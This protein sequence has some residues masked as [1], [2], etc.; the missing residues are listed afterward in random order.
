MDAWKCLVIIFGSIQAVRVNLKKIYKNTEAFEFV[1]AP[2]AL[3][4]AFAELYS[5]HFWWN[6]PFFKWPHCRI[7]IRCRSQSGAVWTGFS[8][9]T[10]NKS[11]NMQC[12]YSVLFPFCHIHSNSSCGTQAN[13][14]LLF[15]F[16]SFFF[17]LENLKE[18][19]RFPDWM[20][21]N[22]AG[23]I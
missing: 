6:N 1:C 13:S 21:T 17:P 4:V 15:L 3:Q 8:D 10:T 7:L 18:Q 12:V 5:L 2:S 22:H 9:S 14:C 23:K 20:M 19:Q 16:W 11:E